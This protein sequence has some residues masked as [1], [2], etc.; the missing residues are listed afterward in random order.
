MSACPLTEW[1]KG[2]FARQRDVISAYG[3]GDISREQF[4]REIK[5]LNIDYYEAMWMAKQIEQQ[6]AE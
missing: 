2:F 3:M 5:N 6:A 1:E 4:L